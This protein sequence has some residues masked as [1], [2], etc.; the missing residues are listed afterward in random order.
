M[1]VN[2]SDG[3]L[4]LLEIARENDRHHALEKNAA[5]VKVLEFGEELTRVC[6][7]EGLEGL[8]LL[9]SAVPPP[10][11]FLM[12]T[13]AALH[14]IR[15]RIDEYVHGDALEAS[16]VRDFDRHALQGFA[17][18]L[19]DLGW[20]NRNASDFDGPASGVFVS[21][22][23][24]NDLHTMWLRTLQHYMANIFQ[25]NFAALRMRER[26]PELDPATEVDLRLSDARLLAE[27]V[28]KLYKAM[29][30]DKNDPEVLAFAL[31]QAINEMLGVQSG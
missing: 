2:L 23:A 13:A 10:Q 24:Q 15:N 18:A 21:R 7:Q 17:E 19:A 12:I 28:M 16:P 11:N 22:L 6:K 9:L 3:A 14:E 25:D 30:N 31:Y 4:Y 27:H 20:P 26:V 8:F 29:Q 5:L 1:N